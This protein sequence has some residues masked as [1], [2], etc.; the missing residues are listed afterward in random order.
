MLS[1]PPALQAHL[2]SGATTLCSCWRLIR[3]DGVIF[4]FTDH[5][6]NITFGGTDYLAASGAEGSETESTLGLAVGGG[7]IAGA[8]TAAALTEADIIAGRYDAATIETWLVNWSDL[9]QRA[10]LD[11]ATIGEIRRQDRAFVA[12]LRS[13]AAA[14]DED[15]GRL[16]SQRCSAELGD[17]RCR[18]ALSA[19]NRRATGTIAAIEGQT[20]L[21]FPIAPAIAAGALTEGRISFLS[22]A[23]QGFKAAIAFHRREAGFDVLQFD[24]ALE[25]GFAIGDQIEVIVGCD[26]RFAT[27]KAVFANQINFRG[28]PHIPS[29]DHAFGYAERGNGQNDGGSLFR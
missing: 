14:Y 20:G 4:G 1:F 17:A 25:A 2:D 15:K 7:E 27:C 26:K 23:S 6:R 11:V 13:A 19:A 3:R 5:D 8:L 12:E 29:A 28:F 10:L 22:G 24:R 21:S 16:Y 18:I 9:A